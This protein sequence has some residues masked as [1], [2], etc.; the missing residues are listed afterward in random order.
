MQ[1]TIQE[2]R[3]FQVAAKR[4]LEDDAAAVV[5]AA[6]SKALSDR[7]ERRRRNGQVIQRLLRAAEAGAE[8]LKRRGVVVVAV[9]ELKQLHEF[10]EAVRINAALCFEAGA[11]PRA[12]IV[13]RERRTRDADD[14]LVEVMA[15]DQPLKRRKDLL[16]GQVARRSE[17]HERI[18]LG[19]RPLALSGA[20]AASRSTHHTTGPEG[21]MPAA[22]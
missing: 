12:K 9:H 1:G 5:A 8:F 6:G 18:G 19:H 2:L 4:F 13:E 10:L 15:R 17:E 16:E 3:G 7:L 20:P 21:R 14:R 22:G 11:S